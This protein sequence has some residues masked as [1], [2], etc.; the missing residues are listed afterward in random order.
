MVNN[1]IEV[2]SY[3]MAARPSVLN[4]MIADAFAEL[5]L[6]DAFQGARL[7]WHAGDAGGDCQGLLVAAERFGSESS[8]MALRT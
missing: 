1:V 2:V 8:P 7:R 4:F 5:A 3:V 6:A